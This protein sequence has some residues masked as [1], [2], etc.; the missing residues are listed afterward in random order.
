MG[1][2]SKRNKEKTVKV[3]IQITTDDDNNENE[4]LLA[5]WIEVL[6]TVV[7]QVDVP[8]IGDSI[9]KVIK[10][11]IGLKNPFAKRKRGNRVLLAV[12]KN[13]NESVFD[14]DGSI[15]KLVLSVCHDNNYKIR[16]D[17]VIFLKDYFKTNREEVVKSS[18]FQDTYLPELFDFI[19]DED[20]HI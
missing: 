13:L 1:L 2:V 8:F 12:C 10:E 16:R 7:G 15:L 5:S 19:N 20:M 18:R 3:A 9:M 17:G 4:P 11:M 6:E 14:K